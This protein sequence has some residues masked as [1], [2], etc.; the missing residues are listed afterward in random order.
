[1][2]AELVNAVQAQVFEFE[3]M[4]EDLQYQ[5]QNVSFASHMLIAPLFESIAHAHEDP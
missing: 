4:M 1:M 5:K 2:K 3:S